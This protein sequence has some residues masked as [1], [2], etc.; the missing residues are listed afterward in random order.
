MKF[1]LVVFTLVLF[2]FRIVLARDDKS[3]VYGGT[4]PI[5]QVPIGDV[6]TLKKD[7]SNML[8]P[9]GGGLVVKTQL[10][11]GDS[12]V[13]DYSK[14]HP[15]FDFMNGKQTVFAT[16]GYWVV[17]SG[18]DVIPTPDNWF[19][20]GYTEMPVS[21]VSQMMNKTNSKNSES[22]NNIYDS[23]I[24]GVFRQISKASTKSSGTSYDVYSALMTC[25]SFS[26]KDGYEPEKNK[27]TASQ[28]AGSII[29]ISENAKTIVNTLP[30]ETEKYPIKFKVVVTS[31]KILARMGG[32]GS[33]ADSEYAKAA[34]IIS[35]TKYPE[36]HD[37]MKKI[38]RAVKPA[39]DVMRPLIKHCQNRLEDAV[40][41]TYWWESVPLELTC[42][43]LNPDKVEL[44][45]KQWTH[46]H[47]DHDDHDDGDDREGESESVISD[48]TFSS[49]AEQLETAFRAAALLEG[50]QMH[51]KSSEDLIQNKVRCFPDSGHFI[52]K[53]ISSLGF[54]SQKNSDNSF[55]LIDPGL[56]SFPE[57]N[58]AMS[59]D[60]QRQYRNN[61]KAIFMVD[62]VTP[63]KVKA[64][65]NYFLKNS[66]GVVFDMHVRDAGC[67]GGTFFCRAKSTKEK[68]K[69][70]NVG[71]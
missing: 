50:V 5:Q 13:V 24:S 53:V 1:N 48:E 7:L 21:G 28:I 55:S 30:E 62:G 9:R 39:L 70:D 10:Y 64:G 47:H 15:N 60:I 57:G 44:L 12:D 17:P 35:T 41:R 23:E 34:K 36:D 37:S 18:G 40:S 45:I 61:R 4:I 42:Q 56:A 19:S 25:V 14:A 59:P 51:A 16:M 33:T 43:T 27:P 69:G 63:M 31:D 54:K 8:Y 71:G 66:G 49:V 32:E 46:K 20:M 52:D 6:S 2:S 38:R 11:C 3:L 68:S 67:T 29:E 58:Y 65:T 22:V 26:K